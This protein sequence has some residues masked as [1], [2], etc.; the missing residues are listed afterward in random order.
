[1]HK[2]AHSL[3]RL[4]EPAVLIGPVKHFAVT[5]PAYIAGKVRQKL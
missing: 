3:A 2:F 1:M 4:Q 5:S